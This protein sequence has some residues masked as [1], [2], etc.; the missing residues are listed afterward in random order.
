MNWRA[1]LL[2]AGLALALWSVPSHAQ[3][4]LG[5]W[6]PLFK[7][8]DSTMGTNTPG[9]GQFPDQ[10][11]IY[12]LR[13][14]LTDPD[15]QLFATPRISPFTLDN[16]ETAGLT[17]SNFLRNFNL[18]IGVNA[19]NFHDPGTT[20]SPSYTLA[21][22]APFEVGGVQICQG[23]IVSVQEPTTADSAAFL[24]TAS[25]QVTFVP[26]NYPAHSNSGIY[27]AVSG[28]Y[29]I[30]VNGV[31]IGS[32]YI[33][34]TDF[35]HQ[36]NPRTLMGISKDSRYLYIAVIDGR[37]SGYSDGSVDW[38][39]AAW[40]LMLGAWNG[41]NMD[42]GG[43][44]ALVM[45]D[46][47]GFP[48]EINHDSAAADPGTARERTVGSHFGI[49][50]KPLP[51]F[52]NGARALPSDTTATLVWTTVAPATSQVQY[53]QTPAFG[54]TTSVES[55]SQTN[56]SAL[57][58]G[59]T[60]GTGYYYQITASANGN[61]YTSSNF[62]FLTTNY[63]TTTSVFD[64]TNIWSFTTANLDGVNWRARTYDDSGWLGSG[65]GLLWAD[66]RG[67]PGTDIPVPTLTQMPN[68]GS[69]YPYTTYYLRTHFTFTNSVK[70]T[71]LKFMDYVDDGAVFYLNGT[72]LFRVRMPAAPTPIYNSTYAAAL[73]CSGDA[74]CPDYFTISG[75]LVET[76]LLTGD[77]VI[78]AEAHNIAA[79]SRD[80]TFGA[81]LAYTEPFTLNP[82]LAI[83]SS[84][85]LV[86]LSWGQ[87]GFTLQQADSPVG[88]W[89]DVPGPVVASPYSL[90]VP[91]A[92][93]YYR[94]RK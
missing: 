86:T 46:S 3:T 23:Q 28:L 82:P 89:S 8:I 90:P 74:T 80:V 72:E 25:K 30:L 24:F 59:L 31:N 50:A 5:P 1:R 35:V 16:H 41:A 21:E 65:P 52:I 14:D 9:A 94:L 33:N 77:N 75:P 63:V 2:V 40:L 42:G 81:T 6:V 67:A 44:S 38:E 19:N 47:T 85:G 88:S 83:I 51:G 18:Q 68:S 45:Q 71:V 36:P 69:G 92:S 12:A 76:N 70:G 60:P 56:H 15:V 66:V 54:L 55:T 84:D 48:Y 49:F 62:Y 39:A 87:G 27:T 53:G 29:A 32:N 26:T 61:V 34:N 11:V 4:V 58:T 17:V 91:Q 64:L 7:G 22:G 57:L 37:Q 43:S 20:D 13:V 78:A 10:H 79:T 93:R 73:A